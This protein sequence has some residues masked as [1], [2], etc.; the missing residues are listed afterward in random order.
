MRDRHMVVQPLLVFKMLPVGSLVHVLTSSC[1]LPKLRGAKVV[2][3]TT[4]NFRLRSCPP[5]VGAEDGMP[6]RVRTKVV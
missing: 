4:T 3:T 2:W 5:V 1:Q 6:T